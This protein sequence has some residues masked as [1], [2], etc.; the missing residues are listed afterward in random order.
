[1]E[2]NSTP[3]MV[4]DNPER[5]RFEL[6]VG[7]AVAFAEYILLTKRIILTHTEVPPAL[8]GQGLASRL[9]QHAMEF[10]QQHQLEVMPLCPYMA[11][12]LRRHPELQHLLAPGVRI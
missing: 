4:Q 1:M 11:A 5:H 12:Y 8:E 2:P 6:W 10:A 9:A 3:L 7:D